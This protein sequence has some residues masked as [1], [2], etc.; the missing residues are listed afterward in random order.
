MNPITKRNFCPSNG[1]DYLHNCIVCNN[2][3]SLFQVTFA[4]Y[5]LSFPRGLDTLNHLLLIWPKT[6]QMIKYDKTFLD[7]LLVCAQYYCLLQF[8]LNI[9]DLDNSCVDIGSCD[10][11]DDEYFKKRLKCHFW[12]EPLSGSPEVFP[13]NPSIERQDCANMTA[14][15]FWY[16]LRIPRVSLPH[17][18]FAILIVASPGVIIQ[19]IPAGI[20]AVQVPAMLVQASV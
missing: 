20:F 18:C 19:A 5:N 6:F 12:N 8:Q 1:N 15:G 7:S 10:P 9:N 4:L 2:L 14:S 3:F 11:I 16:W 13:C 17:S